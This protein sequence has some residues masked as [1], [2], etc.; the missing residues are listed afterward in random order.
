MLKDLG[1]T[2]HDPDEVYF[3]YQLSGFYKSSVF[4]TLAFFLIIK[5][6]HFF[7]YLGRK[8]HRMIKKCYLFIQSENKWWTLLVA[9]I[10]MNLNQL[11]FGCSLQLLDLGVKNLFDKFNLGVMFAMFFLI[12]FYSFSFYSLLYSKGSKSSKNLIVY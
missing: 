9:L 5:L 2:S 6:I 12:I 8:K 3:L 7:L 10:E 11:V 1:F 4:F